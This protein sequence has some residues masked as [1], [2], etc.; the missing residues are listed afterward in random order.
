LTIKKI[1]SILSSE[2][3]NY[4]VQDSNSKNGRI[5]PLFELSKEL[6]MSI[7]RIREQ[8]EVAR[9]LGFV[10]VK[11]RT[12][13]RS[14]PYSFGPAVRQS[15]AFSVALLPESFQKYYDL[16]NHIEA[17]YW[18]QAV[19]LLTSGDF[20]RLTLLVQMAFIKL[21]NKSVQIP[22]AEHRELHLVIFSRLENP[23]VTGLLEAYWD[24]Y[25]IVGLDL[26][27]D[28]NYLREVWVSH[29]DMI[30]FLINEDFESGHK[31]LL[32][33]LD[34]LHHRSDLFI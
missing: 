7:A 9:V 6:G 24:I 5:P 15:L 32:K 8:L 26:Y 29:R 20:D 27:T 19:S 25:E 16:R 14:L 4:L 3:L 11:P 33:H 12:G 34:L 2:F 18:F 1:H 13:I 28:I 31:I 22:H 10:E 30:N 17:S 23:F 21:N